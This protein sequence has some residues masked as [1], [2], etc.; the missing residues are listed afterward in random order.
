MDKTEFCAYSRA[1]LVNTLQDAKA[2]SIDENHKARTEVLFH[3]ARKR[4]VKDGLN[5]I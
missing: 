4:T 1:E 5:L 3:A 2:G